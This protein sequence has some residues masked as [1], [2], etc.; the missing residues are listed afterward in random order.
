MSRTLKANV[1][2]FL[3]A[4]FWGTT[5]IFQ[6]QA[7]DLLSPMAYTGLRFLL[8]AL[9][10]L[11]LAAPRVLRGLR[12]TSDRPGLLRLWIRGWGSAGCLLFAGISFQ[13]YGL[14][15]TTAGKAGFVTSLYVVLV[16]IIL[17]AAG[18]KILFGEMLGAALAVAGL[19]LLTFSAGM[20]FSRGD[21]LVLIGAFIWACHVLCIGRFSPKMDPVVLGIG[22]T[23]VAG[24]LG[25]AGTAVL[26]QTPSMAILGESWLVVFW[27]GIFSVALGFT[28]Q[29][30][31]QRDANPVAAA[32]IM[33][34]EAVI[35]AATGWLVLNEL[36]TG[37]MIFGAFVM[38]FGFL[39]SQLW[40][41]LFRKP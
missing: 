7:M 14:V 35:A 38:F 17:F 11:P 20:D 26:D 3:S 37:R 31:G 9:A 29:V 18:R 39:A 15:W 27:G 41:L 36:M 16:P 6:R 12:E 33:Q 19:Y 40:P 23:L 5:F 21:G 4:L 25:A 8:G 13:Q 34:M 1:A 28:L 22:Q 30:V 2:L 32:I 10:L 24:V